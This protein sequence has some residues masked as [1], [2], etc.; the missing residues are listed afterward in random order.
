M[1]LNRLRVRWNIILLGIKPVSYPVWHAAWVQGK[2]Y[3]SEFK[4][5]LRT[6]EFSYVLLGKPIHRLSQCLPRDATQSAVLLWQVVCPSVCLSVTL[7]YCDYIGWKSS[8]IISW[9]VSLGRSLFATP[10]S[11]GYSKGNTPKFLPE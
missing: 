6:M 10:T 11:R 9:L 7:R 4:T 1:A 3:L 5:R 8:K 2:T